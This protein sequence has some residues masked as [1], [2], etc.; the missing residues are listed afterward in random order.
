M[1]TEERKTKVAAQTGLYLVVVTGIVCLVNLLASGTYRRIDTTANERY[2]L[3]KGSASL[4]SGLSEPIQI[5]AYIKTGL[6]QLDVFVRDLTD[7]LKEYE[8][9]GQGKFRFT[10]IEANT[11]EL[12]EQAKEAGLQPMAFGEASA[13]GEDQ[14]AI[15]QGYMGLVFKYRSEKDVIPQLHPGQ[16]EGM[17]FWITNKIREIHD[18][19]EDVKHRVGVVTNKDELK[20]SD[21]NLV[22]KAGGR[23]GQSLQGIIQQFFPFYKIE[24]LDLKDGEEPIDEELAGV[25]ITQPRKDYTEKELRRIDEFLMRGDKALAVFASAVTLKPNDASLTAE[26]DLHELD[27]LLIGYGLDIKKNAVFDHGAQVRLPVISGMGQLT[28]LRHPGIPHVVDDPRLQGDERALDTSFPGFF[29]M[30]D[31]TFPFSSSIELLKDKQPADVELRAVAR[32]SPAASVSTEETI[33]MKRSEWSPAPPL[34]QRIIAAVAEGKLK[35]A[36]AGSPDES[37]KANET[38]PKASRVLLVASSEFLTNPFSYAGNGPD[39]GGQFQ[40]FGGVG[41][42]QQLLMVAQPYAQRFLTNVILALK[43]TLDWISGDTDL[44]AASAKMMGDA[45]LTYASLAVPKFAAEDDEAERKRKDEEYQAARKAL[46]QKIQ[47]S[48]TLGVPL[49]FAGFGFARWRRRETRR[50]TVSA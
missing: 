9:A 17:E 10:L 49:V 42:D 15:A 33:D 24:E 13:T 35:S 38:A 4:V 34:D 25:I 3:S 30:Q 8:G 11:D 7:L 16:A 18:K 46:Q 2:T 41:G 31:L 50:S 44:I 45:N 20:L 14:A 12:R 26:L 6:A 29:R 37:I 23:G 27:K 28:W 36:F 21:T 22:P 48:L 43:N 19:A 32:T 1:A 47:W 40:M 39:L 5:D